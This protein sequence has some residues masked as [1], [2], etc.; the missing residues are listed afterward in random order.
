MIES[1]LFYLLVYLIIGFA[2]SFINHYKESTKVEDTW[3]Y[4]LFILMAFIWPLVHIHL[5]SPFW[6]LNKLIDMKEERKRKR[7]LNKGL[8]K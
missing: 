5:L 7:K 4:F 1:Y 6:Y 8:V 3:E 2:W